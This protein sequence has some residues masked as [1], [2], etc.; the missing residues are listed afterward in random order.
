MVFQDAPQSSI[1]TPQLQVL[2][3]PVSET[4][5]RQQGWLQCTRSPP[6]QAGERMDSGARHTYSSSTRVASIFT[7]PNV[8]GPITCFRKS[9]PKSSPKLV[10]GAW[11]C[12]S[13]FHYLINRLFILLL[14]GLGL[15]RTKLEW[16]RPKQYGS[17]YSRPKSRMVKVG[18]GVLHCS[19]DPC[20]R[21][22]IAACR[23]AVV[24]RQ[25]L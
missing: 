25:G 8:A 1:Q 13:T 18:N 20:H 2:E 21:S 17:R 24:P 6:L 22:S 9:T 3:T 10:N 23:R 14:E 12:L 7:L 19:S 5:Y 11:R 16:V 4:V 15:A